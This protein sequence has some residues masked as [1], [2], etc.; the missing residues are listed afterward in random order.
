MIPAR[1]RI[2]ARRRLRAR[3]LRVLP[4]V[5]GHREE[6]IVNDE[7]QVMTAC[8]QI[9]RGGPAARLAGILVPVFLAVAAALQGVPSE[10]LGED[11]AKL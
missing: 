5:S 7:V 9:K 3:V 11:T 10:E 4:A 8:P 6:S 2:A 1:G